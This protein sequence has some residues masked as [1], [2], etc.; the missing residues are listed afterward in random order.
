MVEFKTWHYRVL[1]WSF[2]IMLFCLGLFL[3][4]YLTKSL[5]ESSVNTTVNTTGGSWGP[6]LEFK[7]AN[8]SSYRWSNITIEEPQNLTR[9]S[10]TC[11]WWIDG[12][13]E[14]VM[15]NLSTDIWHNITLTCIR[16]ISKNIYF[17]REPAIDYPDSPRRWQ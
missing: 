13:L 17:L 11:T 2:W 15:T 7:P 6:M 14:D 5:A 9:G 10:I 1:I 12:R 8:L 16:N 4:F 3:F